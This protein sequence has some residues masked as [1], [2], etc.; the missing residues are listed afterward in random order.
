MKYAYL[1]FY[2]FYLLFKEKEAD[3]VAQNEEERYVA[4]NK[5]NAQRSDSG[6][7]YVINEAGTENNLLQLQMYCSVQRI[8]H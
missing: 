3:Y 5:L 6:L 7:Y 4:K 8:F 1:L 2:F